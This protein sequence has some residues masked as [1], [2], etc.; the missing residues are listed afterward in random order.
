MKNRTEV[1]MYLF[2]HRY[3]FRK[4]IARDLGIP[5]STLS[6]VIQELSR[7][8]VIKSFY[9][10]SQTRG[11][12]AQVITLN[13]NAWKGLSIKIGREN[14]RFVSFDTH[15]NILRTRVFHVKR[16]Q[17]NNKGYLQLLKK[18]LKNF[19]DV[20]CIG[21]CSSG[22]VENGKI[23]FSPIMNVKNLELGEIVSRSIPVVF[24]NDVE[25]LTCFERF[26]FG[27]NNFLVV[28]YGTG[29]GGAYL[30]DNERE[31]FDLGHMIISNGE[32][33][34]CGQSGCLETFASDYAV[35]KKFMGLNF[36]IIDF[37]EL[38]E[39]KFSKSLETL[40]E[41]AKKR[42]QRVKEYYSD[43]LEILSRVLGNLCLIFRPEKVAFYGEGIARWMVKEI[44]RRIKKEFLREHLND[45]SFVYRG[46]IDHSW[47]MGIYTEATKILI[48]GF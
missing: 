40:R 24:M 39:E 15:M 29:V 21:V 16:Y 35:L 20:S 36:S 26:F 43:S 37:V 27:G 13:Q 17:R 41:L 4:D 33:C 5:A 32:K 28:N 6:Y 9:Q 7:K 22:T 42:P 44:E 45:I 12:P 2:K 19:D 47:E 30:K 18:G 1:L 14:V 46:E 31:F 8:K 11:R 48:E 25:A 34:Y 3:V 10:P 38:E 23:V